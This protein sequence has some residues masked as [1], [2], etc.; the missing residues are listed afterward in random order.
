MMESSTK[1]DFKIPKKA[2]TKTIKKPVNEYKLTKV[3]EELESLGEKL[4]LVEKQMILNSVDAEKLLELYKEK[5]LLED[6]YE[7]TFIH[8]EKLQK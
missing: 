5:E 7:E 6:E 8:W 1:N 2:Q 4:N 3:E